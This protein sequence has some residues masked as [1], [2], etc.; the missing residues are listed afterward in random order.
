MLGKAKKYP[1]VVQP[2]RLASEN[3]RVGV[4]TEERE[5]ER[6]N[7]FLHSLFPTLLEASGFVV[8]EGG[9]VPPPSCVTLTWVFLFTKKHTGFVVHLHRYT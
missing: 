3:E 9:V 8:L 5:R 4:S 7:I 6:K 2:R 1:C